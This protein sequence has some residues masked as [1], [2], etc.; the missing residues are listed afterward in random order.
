MEDIKKLHNK[1]NIGLVNL[2]E[3]TENALEIAEKVTKERMTDDE[4]VRYQAFQDKL[5]DLTLKG[6]HK[7]V[8]EL[9]KAYLKENG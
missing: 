1:L 6:K 8:E 3:L 7:E 9:K 4:F 5:I 2:S